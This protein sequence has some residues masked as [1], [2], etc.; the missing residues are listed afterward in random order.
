MTFVE[1]RGGGAGEL[2]DVLVGRDR[3]RVALSDAMA[4]VAVR[5]GAPRVA[6]WWASSYLSVVRY[7][8]RSSTCRAVSDVLKPGGM[9]ETPPAE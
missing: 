2:S 7:A 5:G 6:H 1:G 8:T 4:A 9:N 3:E